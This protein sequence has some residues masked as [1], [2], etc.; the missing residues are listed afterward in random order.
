MI[1]LFGEL[2]G[3]TARLRATSAAAAALLAVV[4]ATAS[5]SLPPLR[6][7]AASPA[8][9][10][11]TLAVCKKDVVGFSTLEK[12]DMRTNMCLQV[13]QVLSHVVTFGLPPFVG[14]RCEWAPK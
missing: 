1:A 9:M 12:R 14:A 2:L 6:A 7:L 3:P 4:R 8:A 5:V 11:C 10:T 13:G